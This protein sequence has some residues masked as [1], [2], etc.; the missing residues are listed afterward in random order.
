MKKFP[1]IAIF[2]TLLIVVAGAFVFRKSSEPTP[3]PS[4]TSQGRVV[5]E[6]FWSETCPH[7]ANV[8]SFLD[9]WEGKEKIF[10]DKKSVYSNKENSFLLT[11]RAS[12]CGIP[13]N[14]I[15]VPFLYTPDSKCIIGDANI[16]EYFKSLDQ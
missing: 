5:H 9:G 13:A 1:A 6:Y 10:L 8:Q 2:L 4:P 12:G 15:G 3:S 14:S 16:I 11:K 7:C